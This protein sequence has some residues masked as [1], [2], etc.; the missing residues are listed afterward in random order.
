MT[1]PHTWKLGTEGDALPVLST[2]SGVKQNSWLA[3]NPTL[4]TAEANGVEAVV[5]ALAYE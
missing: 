3:H 2:I 5:K 4:I 1:M